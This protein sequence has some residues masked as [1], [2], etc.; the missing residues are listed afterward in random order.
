[1]VA[2]SISNA[3]L[4]MDVVVRWGGEEFVIILPGA[5]PVVAK[6]IAERVR[7]LIDSSFISHGTA[8]LLVTVSI[9]GTV[10]REGETAES[11]VKRADS[12]MYCSKDN[13]RNRVTIDCLP[14]SDVYNQSM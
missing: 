5:T 10:A 1:M 12:L 6:A 4:N 14:W 8:D 3:L 2:K 13:G 9:G 11:I 7:M